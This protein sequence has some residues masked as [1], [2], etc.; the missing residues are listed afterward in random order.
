M[1]SNVKRLGLLA[2]LATL[3]A[4]AIALPRIGRRANPPAKA[5][6]TSSTRSRAAWSSSTSRPDGARV[7]KGDI[8]CELDPD[9]AE[10]SAGHAGDRR[11]RRRGR[12]PRHQDR[13]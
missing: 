13:P 5:V 3:L 6:S 1:S 9:R 10:G 12:C 11:P 8:V 4:G 7:A 2:G